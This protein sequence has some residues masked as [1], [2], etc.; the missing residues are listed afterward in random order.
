MRT[1]RRPKIAGTWVL[2]LRLYSCAERGWGAGGKHEGI[3]DKQ[4]ENST[5]RCRGIHIG[6]HNNSRVKSFHGSSLA[7]RLWIRFPDS[8]GLQGPGRWRE[9]KRKRRGRPSG[10]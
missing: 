6:P 5:A 9:T 1:Q 4:L 7:A 8:V 3:G 2:D 10:R